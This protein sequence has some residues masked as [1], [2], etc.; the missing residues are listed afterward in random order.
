MKNP[1][2]DISRFRSRFSSQKVT[3]LWYQLYRRVF[4]VFFAAVLV[5]GAWYWYYSLYKYSWSERT[6]KAFLDSYVQE[7]DFKEASFKK[8]VSTSLE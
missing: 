2:S 5:A 8:A 1:F 4:L 6:K 3:L 7:T